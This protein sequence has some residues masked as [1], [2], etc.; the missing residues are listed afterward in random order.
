MKIFS[1]MKDIHQMNVAFG[2]A[3]KAALNHYGLS[4]CH[5]LVAE[6]HCMY[7]S[8]IS[9]FD[10]TE[11]IHEGRKHLEKARKLA[12]RIMGPRHPILSTYASEVA[13]IDM[14]A[15][16]TYA[17]LEHYEQ[18]LLLLQSSVG[19]NSLEASTMYY[20]MARIK[21]I[22][23]NQLGQVEAEEALIFAEK[24]LRIREMCAM[25][26]VE[27]EGQRKDE[28]S[29]EKDGEKD[30]EEEEGGGKESDGGRVD[31]KSLTSAMKMSTDSENF[32]PFFLFF[33]FFFSFLFFS[34]FAVLSDS[35][36]FSFLLSS[37]SSLLLSLAVH[38]VGALTSVS[39]NMNDLLVHSYCQVAEMASEERKYERS[40]QCFER[41][42][43]C[44]R[45]RPQKTEAT[46]QLMQRATR[47][48]VSIK[49]IELEFHIAEKVRKC[50]A[51][52][53]PHKRLHEQNKEIFVKVI[54]TIMERSPGEYFEE[55]M[56]Q[57]NM[58]GGGKQ[59]GKEEEGGGDMKHDDEV[60]AKYGERRM[61]NVTCEIE[62]ACL[63][64]LS[65]SV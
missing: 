35:C 63:V 24:S 20:E 43:V 60:G 36:S 22:H 42:I 49:M 44:L 14:L 10:T 6:L 15:G 55:L 5:P 7:G 62:L 56:E 45:A 19:L 57:C 50:H 65:E 26:K 38:I 64:E 41:L 29:G 11:S 53:D 18:A 13:R 39:G 4:G 33:F 51:R 8:L 12:A 3:L 21:Q 1:D 9:E 61:N 16:D 40:M 31:K 25:I 46:L 37:F 30:G 17:A 58:Y 52:H 28:E 2:S 59:H 27:S 47:E 32:F 34:L 23:G 54:Q 48:I